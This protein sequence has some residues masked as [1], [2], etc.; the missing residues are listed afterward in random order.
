MPYFVKTHCF[1]LKVV[2]VFVRS[3]FFF[4]FFQKKKGNMHLQNKFRSQ[5]HTCAD[6]L[7]GFV[8]P[9]WVTHAVFICRSLERAVY[10][11]RRCLLW[12][13]MCISLEGEII[14]LNSV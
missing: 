10:H 9:P 2:F 5:F 6:T 8:I 13:T 14:H 1:Q 7:P 11:L 4:F 12:C 3:A